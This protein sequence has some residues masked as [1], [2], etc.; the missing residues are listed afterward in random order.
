M[1]FL[2]AEWRKLVFAN[3]I[4]APQ[5]LQPHVPYGTE[6]DLWQD[7]CYASLVGFKF[8]NVRVLGIKIPFHVNFEEVNLRFYVKRKEG[9]EWRRGV[10]F[11]KEIVPKPAI[12]FVANTIYKENYQTLPM[13]H[14]W[15]TLDG[16]RTVAYQWKTNS[17]WHTCKVLA[18]ETPSVIPLGGE[19]EFI[20]EHYWGYAHNGSHRTN[21]YE[22]TH[23]KWEQYDVQR[24]QIEVDYGEVYGEKFAFLNE[25]KPSSVM[26]AE[27]SPIT[28]ETKRVIL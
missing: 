15:Q 4:V 27:G 18:A 16:Q 11:I 13:R 26:L 20:T 24:Y 28:V 1:S 19:T 5:I 12:T 14:H 3:Y 21:E 17:G 25:L 7:N 9:N 23:P 8:V 2:T 6:L 22:V 10:V